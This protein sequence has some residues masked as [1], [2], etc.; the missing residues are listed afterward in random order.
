MSIEVFKLNGVLN[1]L[2][3]GSIERR[4]DRPRTQKQYL[5]FDKNLSWK[6]TIERNPKDII[7]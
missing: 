7:C 1:G 5:V 4:L 3:N 2:L 6:F